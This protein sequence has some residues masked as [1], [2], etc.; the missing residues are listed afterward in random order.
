MG[1]LDRQVAIVTG[2]G[3]GIEQAIS[4][5]LAQAGAAVAVAARSP[6]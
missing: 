5:A 4:R 1:E 6:D 3:R 2:G